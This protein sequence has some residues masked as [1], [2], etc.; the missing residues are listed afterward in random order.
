MALLA[1][2]NDL[3]RYAGSGS[4]LG[5]YTG[6]LQ[7]FLDQEPAAETALQLRAGYSLVATMV[8]HRAL[9]ENDPP[10]DDATLDALKSVRNACEKVVRH[11]ESYA[12]A[13]SVLAAVN[14]LAA[15][16]ETD[17]DP[18]ESKI[19]WTPTDYYNAACTWASPRAGQNGPRD[20]E[21]AVGAVDAGRKRPLAR[22]VVIYRQLNQLRDTD[23]FRD[24]FGP[25]PQK[26]IL[27][28]APF[29]VYAEKLRAGGFGSPEAMAQA[30]LGELEAV[31]APAMLTQRVKDLAAT[32]STIPGPLAAWRA[33]LCSRC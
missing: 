17:T 16:I 28:I 4:D 3:Y 11:D 27:T 31:G 19:T 5:R 25:K 29:A 24:A 2:W 20:V 8:N 18:P 1:H 10:G 12:L 6:M 14:A 13:K 32:A 22:A 33:R 26:D 7:E 15:S 23:A 30:S 9:G 21:K